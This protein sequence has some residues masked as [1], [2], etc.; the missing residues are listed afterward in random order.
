MI[1]TFTDGIFTIEVI[2]LIN[3]KEGVNDLKD[4]LN[5]Y[6]QGFLI[7]R[8][9]DTNTIVI[10]NPITTEEYYLSEGLYLAVNADYSISTFQEEE[11]KDRFRE[12]KPLGELVYGVTEWRDSTLSQAIQAP[13]APTALQKQ[14]GG[15]HYKNFAIQPVEFITANNLGY[16]EGNVIKYICRHE[17]KNGRQD[18]EKAIHYIEMLMDLKYPQPPELE[19]EQH[20]FEG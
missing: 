19:G 17:H 6:K 2:L 15:S 9:Q 10:E 16:I 12:T 18:L 14:V 1:N 4:F 8:R 3:S 20:S 11:L 13:E 7:D 5:K